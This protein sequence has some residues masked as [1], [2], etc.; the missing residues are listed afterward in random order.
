MRLHPSVWIPIY[1]YELCLLKFLYSFISFSQKLWDV[2]QSHSFN[3]LQYCFNYFQYSFHIE[4]INITP[5]TACLGARSARSS[6]LHARQHCRHTGQTERYVQ[7]EP[8]VAGSAD[9]HLAHADT[10]QLST[11]P[12]TTEG[13]CCSRVSFLSHKILPMGWLSYSGCIKLTDFC[14]LNGLC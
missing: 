9:Q 11:W 4:C 2:N 14:N 3:Y 6:S 13:Y 1:T 5:A 12:T 10:E 7:W 8:Q